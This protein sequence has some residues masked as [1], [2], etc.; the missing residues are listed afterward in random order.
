MIFSLNK[1]AAGHRCEHKAI[2]DGNMDRKVNAIRECFS[3][4]E[5]VIYACGES[6]SIDKKQSVHGGDANEAY[7]LFLSNGEILFLKRN[8]VSNA[9]FFRAE[10]EGIAAIKLAGKI[11]V[12]TVYARG[13][14]AGHS[15]VLMEYIESGRRQEDFWEQLGAGLAAMHKADTALYLERGKYGFDRDNYIGAGYQKN[16]PMD[17]WTGFF[18]E[19]RLRP[20][21]ILAEKYFDSS[22]VR[23]ADRLLDNIDRYLYEPDKPSLLHGDLWGGNFMSD[24]NGSPVLIDPATYVGC[25]EADIAMTELF[26]GFDRRFYESYFDSMG[27]VPGYEERRE[28][29]N[30]YHLTNHLNLFGRTYLSSVVRIIKRFSV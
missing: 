24:E 15:F 12:P 13:T 5:A 23:A 2:R 25:N 9:D 27:V 8:T 16:T 10:A 1:K 19:C 29:Y 30:L 17:S 22:A 4:E 21:F 6:V 14:D 20:Q 28:L 26:G 18:S 11:R 7:K 3:L